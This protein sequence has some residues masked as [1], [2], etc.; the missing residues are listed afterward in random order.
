MKRKDIISYKQDALMDEANKKAQSTFGYFWRELYWEY[1]RMVPLLTN[2]SVKFPFTQDKKNREHMW[3]YDIYFD[4]ETI[5]GRVGNE[6][7]NLTNIKEGDLVERKVSEI[8]DWAFSVDKKIYGGFTIR[9]LRSKMSKKARK[10]YDLDLGIEFENNNKILLAIG[11]EYSEYL[12]DH[13]MSVYMQDSFKKYLLQNPSEIFDFDENG[14]TLLHTE[15]I[16]GNKAMVEVLLELGAD[17]NAKSKFGKTAYD[18][19]KQMNW[20]YLENLL[21]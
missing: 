21:Y 5:K 12:I 16:A 1:R 6:P 4:G 17:K 18:Y 10:K 3:L 13:P 15:T 2:A 19:A 9:L 8:S 14:F 7:E 20:K 11:Q